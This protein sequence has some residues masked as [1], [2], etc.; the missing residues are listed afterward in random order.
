MRTFAATTAWALAGAGL[1]AA[2]FWAFLNTPESTIWTL[3]LSSLLALAMLVLTGVA[4]NASLIAWTTGWSATAVARAGRGLLP[5][6]LAL[7]VVAVSWW[8]F[9]RAQGWVND[10]SGEISAWFIA[11]LGWSDVQPLITLA[12]WLCEWLRLLAVPFAALAWLARTLAPAPASATS[13]ASSQPGGQEPSGAGPRLRRALSPLGLALATAV[14]VV[15]LWLPWTYGARWVPRGLPATWV[16]PA[17]AVVKFA[18][19][20]LLAAIG[21]TLLTRLA[22]VGI[23]RRSVR[24]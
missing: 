20:A 8:L 18:A 12:W 10:R 9:G 7:A 19:M 4:V 1:N 14:G 16:E 5:F 23:A 21:V 22:A 17:F 2:L 13:E 15:F 11:T 3:G 24:L 6:S